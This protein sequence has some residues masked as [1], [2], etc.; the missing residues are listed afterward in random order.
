[1]SSN[2]RVLAAR[3]TRPCARIQQSTSTATISKRALHVDGRAR[4]TTQWAPSGG[5]AASVDEDAHGKLIRAGFLRQTHSGIFHLL[6]FGLRVQEKLTRLIDRYMQGLGASKLQMSAISSEALW[7]QSGRLSKTGSELFRFE[8]RKESRFLLSPTHEEEITSLV[9]SSVSS[10]KTLPL[11]LYQITAKYR[12]ELRPRQGL[13]RGRDFSM[14]DLYTFDFTAARALQ[15]YESVREAYSKIFVDEM[16]L[17]ILVAEASSGDI[18]GDLSHEYHIPTPLG[19]DNVMSCSS[20]GYVANEE[21]ATSRTVEPTRDVGPD[22]V[23][24]WRGISK[25]RKTF[26]NV[27]YVGDEGGE[28]SSSSSIVNV[29][30]LK[31]F[32]PE[33]D[34][35]LEH[36]ASHWALALESSV[37][38]MRLV[39]L[40]DSRVPGKTR[41]DIHNSKRFV[42]P[43]LKKYMGRISY[44]KHS[45]ASS[46][47]NLLRIHDGDGCPRCPSGTLT[48]QKAIELGHTFHLGTR[49]S[50]LMNA[51]INVPKKLLVEEAAEIKETA[52]G[53]AQHPVDDP[54]SASP[55]GTAAVVAPAPEGS[56][57]VH[58]YYQMGCHG[59]GV[60][61]I[62]GAVANH[63]VDKRGLNWPRVIAPY[64]AI[65]VYV[66]KQT[67]PEEAN[68]VHDLL[69]K[70][71]QEHAPVDTI[72]DDR[73]DFSIGWKLND[74]DLVGYPVVVVLG[75]EWRTSKKAEVQCRRLDFKQN[76]PLD[77]LK[78]CVSGL[79][80]KL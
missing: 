24:V 12:D 19:E 22:E 67:D 56:T 76:V 55:T 47:V 46:N 72:L 48:V 33:L 17:P 26:V 20:C 18:G 14:K 15:T 11:R 75:R 40:F 73:P 61:R 58:V 31:Q 51:S 8:D 50:E 45:R 80:S 63:L 52:N 35:S 41:H 66:T 37:E 5:I 70:E 44:A 36:A 71:E 65:V 49:Y 1:M 2:M 68:M 28:P 60:S 78:S 38:T 16:K 32:V 29:H 53:E 79:L 54:V 62:I 3:L 4:L 39:N 21:V 10:Y 7:E 77:E 23:S 74:A 43:E 13:L 34:A 9:A 42:P 64:E 27:W 59:I 57:S 25:D 6:P 69:Q 30:T